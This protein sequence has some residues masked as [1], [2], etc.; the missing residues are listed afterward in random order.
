[1]RL[2]DFGAIFL[3]ISLVMFKD[4]KDEYAWNI[5][6]LS[7][8]KWFVRHLSFISM[9]IYILLFGVLNNDQFIYF[10]F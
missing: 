9:I 1:M 6:L 8:E 3:A 7:S 5:H 4:M 10:Q 2:A